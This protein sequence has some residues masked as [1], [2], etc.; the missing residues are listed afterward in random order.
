MPR[1]R[2]SIRFGEY[3]HAVKVSRDEGM[4]ALWQHMQRQFHIPLQ[5]FIIASTGPSPGLVGDEEGTFE[6][7]T[8]PLEKCQVAGH[9]V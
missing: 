8:P 5:P 4:T 6:E 1:L 2:Q 3:R 7:R 9:L